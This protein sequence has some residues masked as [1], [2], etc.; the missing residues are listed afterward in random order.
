VFSHNQEGGGAVALLKSFTL[1][2]G[3]PGPA[4]ALVT[5][6]YKLS[7]VGEKGDLGKL[8]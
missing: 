7:S 3:S 4:S 2:K 1:P 5:W 8:S 6:E